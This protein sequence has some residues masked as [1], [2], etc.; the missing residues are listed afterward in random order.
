MKAVNFSG[1]NT[2]YVAPGCFD[3]PTMAEERGGN[4]EV[5][6]CWK[7]SAEELEIL[8]AGGCVCLCVRGGQ[9]PVALWAQSVEIIE[10]EE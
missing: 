7:P 2:T 3:L 9:P 6:S 4:L 8:N 5:T 10:Q 1:M